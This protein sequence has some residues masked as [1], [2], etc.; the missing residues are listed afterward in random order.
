MSNFFCYLGNEEHKIIIVGLDNA[1]KVDLFTT[2]RKK[3]TMIC[4]DLR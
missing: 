3:H 1:G 2:K 4:F